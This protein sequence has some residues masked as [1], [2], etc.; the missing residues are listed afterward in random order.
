MRLFQKP[1]VKC[2]VCNHQLHEVMRVFRRDFRCNQC[3]C[4]LYASPGYGRTLW[5][6]SALLG[7]ILMWA[8]GTRDILHLSLYLL[9]TTFLVFMIALRVVP[10]VVA[11]RLISGKPEHLTTLGL[12]GSPAKQAEDDRNCDK[13]D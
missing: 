12:T 10:V 13:R 4:P 3:G 6:V 8:S 11:P 2:P 7:F 9:P 5:F 1:S